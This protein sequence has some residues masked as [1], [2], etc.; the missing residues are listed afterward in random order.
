MNETEVVLATVLLAY[1]SP[2]TCDVPGEIP[3]RS[4]TRCLQRCEGTGRG[5]NP[6]GLELLLS[7]G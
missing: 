6:T 1:F 4:L 5:Y 2:V 7:H 3:E